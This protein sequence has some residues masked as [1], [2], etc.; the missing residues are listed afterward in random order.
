MIYKDC[1]LKEYISNLNLAVYSVS[2]STYSSI[3]VFT[4]LHIPGSTFVFSVSTY[5]SITLL[6]LC[7]TRKLLLP[8]E[9]F[10]ETS[11]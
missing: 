6:L 5:P 2:M 9:L 8:L 1:L 11:G 10:S 7:Y 4:L 3:T